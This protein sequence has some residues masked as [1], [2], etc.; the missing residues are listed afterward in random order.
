MVKRPKKYISRSQTRRRRQLREQG[1]RSKSR[2]DEEYV[3]GE[4]AL[5]PYLKNHKIEA[6]FICVLI[7][8]AAAVYVLR[9]DQKVIQEKK[10]AVSSLL[11]DQSYEWGRA[12]PHGYKIIAFT[13]ENII[14]TNYDT[15]PEELT[16]DWKRFSATRIQA[17]R[18]KSTEEKIRIK[19]PG[20]NYLPAGVSNLS[21]TATLLR[22]KGAIGHL[23]KFGKMALIAEI[24]EER[25]GYVFC[26]FGLK[27]E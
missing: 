4:F 17:N 22:Q 7:F 10:D 1:Q 8:Y 14:H 23:A 5:W 27:D 12:Y 13:D 3:Y 16:F 18:I 2:D 9:P 24:L 15:L 11:L 26:L 21:I 19:M 25:E 6:L 20:I